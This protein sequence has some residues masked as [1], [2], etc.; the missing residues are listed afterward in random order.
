MSAELGRS[1]AVTLK[2]VAAAAGVSRSTASRAL[3]GSTLIAPATR[4]AVKEAAELLHYR[5]NRAASTLRSKQSHLVGLVLNNLINASFHTIAEVVQRRASTEGYQVILC[6]TDADVRTEKSFLHMLADHGVDGLIVIGTGQNAATSNRLYADGTAVVNVIRAPQ[7]G[8]PPSVLAADREGAF[9]ATT[10][11]L[12]LGH[13]RIGFIGGPPGTNSGDERYAGYVQAL[14]EADHA[15]DERLVRRGPFTADFGVSA[16]TDLLT[17]SPSVTA[18]LAANHEAVFGVLPTLVA[19]HVRVP[20]D[21]SLICYEDISWL[22]SW[23]PP[24]TVV[25]NGAHELGALAIDLLLQQ[26]GLE[27]RS[28]AGT[29]ERTG[30]TYRVGAQLIQRESCRELPTVLPVR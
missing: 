23:Q 1:T 22:R 7:G 15:L 9:T 6:I 13:V 4:L 11:L 8:A 26:M 19:E 24:I 27:G 17:E 3:S 28:R 25:D 16:V 5:P 30:R 21:L 14:R 10:H 29:P 2:D 18:L 12:D 20:E